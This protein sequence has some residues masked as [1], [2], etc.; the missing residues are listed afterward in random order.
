VE[1]SGLVNNNLRAR[2]IM[3]V[4]LA[5]I[6]DDATVSEAVQQMRLEGVRS[7][8]VEPHNDQDA[9][10]II[11]HSDIVSK[12]LAQDRDPEKTRVYEVMAKPVISISP[13]LEVRYIARMF[14]TTGV[15][16]L[17]VLDGHEIAG[18]VSMT[19]L[20]TEVIPEP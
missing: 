12:V 8:L 14:Q 11:T 16:H 6:L 18:M 15:S 5:T 10:G 4:E 1:V 7:L 17:P 9:Y 3:Q 13:W 2:D 20:V 19:D